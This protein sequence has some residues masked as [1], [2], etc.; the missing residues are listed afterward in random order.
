MKRIVANV[1]A[2]EIRMVVL[3]EQNELVDTAFY[4]PTRD[5]TINHIY[6]GIVRNVLPGMSAAFVDIGL[7]QNAYLNLKQ[8]KQTKAMGKLF[9][10]QNILV[11]VVKEEMLGKGRASVRREPGRSFYGA[12]A[13]FGRAPYFQAYYR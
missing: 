8:G 7:K 10:G 9:V 5:E 6:K 13:L 2:E 4:R 1:M 11:Q 12:F 3:D